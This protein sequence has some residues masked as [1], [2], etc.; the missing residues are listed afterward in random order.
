MGITTSQAT[1]HSAA[2]FS[3][4]S[5]SFYHQSNMMASPQPSQIVQVV[6]AMTGQPYKHATAA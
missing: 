4:Q 6:Q 1:K 3:N 2:E 5:G